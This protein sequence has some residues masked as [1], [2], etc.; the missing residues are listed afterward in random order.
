MYVGLWHRT[1]HVS[2]LPQTGAAVIDVAS[3]LPASVSRP[4]TNITCHGAL[5]VR[6]LVSGAFSQLG[7]VEMTISV[8]IN[9][10]APEISADVAPDAANVLADALPQHADGGKK[11][12]RGDPNSAKHGC[13]RRRGS[14]RPADRAAR[15]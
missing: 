13:R 3:V 1:G 10:A 9:A 12:A 2:L 4:G 14:R 7:P 15:E 5:H 8:P 6:D 11:A